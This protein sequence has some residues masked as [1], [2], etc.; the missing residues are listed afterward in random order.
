MREQ[1][2]YVHKQIAFFSFESQRAR[3]EKI[4]ACG[5]MLISPPNPGSEDA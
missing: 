3:S 1:G 4:R 2:N 5:K